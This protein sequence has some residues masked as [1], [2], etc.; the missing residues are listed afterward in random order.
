MYKHVSIRNIC[1]LWLKSSFSLI[2]SSQGKI[3]ALNRRGGEI[4]L[5][6]KLLLN[7]KREIW[8]REECVTLMYWCM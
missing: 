1:S 4:K 8:L 5:L 7:V 2:I 6:F 3:D